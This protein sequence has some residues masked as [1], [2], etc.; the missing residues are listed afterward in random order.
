MCEKI[1]E[2]LK[3]ILPERKI[4]GDL[5]IFPPQSIVSLNS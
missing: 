4:G 5:Y 3:N 1:I 2:K